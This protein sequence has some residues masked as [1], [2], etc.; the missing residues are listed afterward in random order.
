MPI[1]KG[2]T[3]EAG[4]T[5]PLTGCK[6]NSR[7]TVPN[8]SPALPPPFG[9]PPPPQATKPLAIANAKNL[10]PTREGQRR[11][12]VVGMPTV[13]HS[14]NEVIDRRH[15]DLSIENIENMKFGYLP[16]I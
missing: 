13:L 8:G 2:V 16:K 12:G 7:V 6:F 3:A 10:R 1:A 15:A 11:I 14:C 9:D 4:K 5:T